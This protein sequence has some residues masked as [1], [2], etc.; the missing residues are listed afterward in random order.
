MDPVQLLKL[1]AKSAALGPPIATDE[2]LTL[3][4]PVTFNDVTWGLLV[5][6]TF[7]GPNVRLR[8]VKLT[9]VT[10]GIPTPS[11]GDA[12]RTSAGGVY[13]LDRGGSRSGRGGLK[14]DLNTATVSGRDGGAGGLPVIEKSPGL[15]EAGSMA[16][17]LKLTVAVPALKTDTQLTVPTPTLRGENTRAVGLKVNV[18]VAACPI[19]LKRYGLRTTRRVVGE[20]RATRCAGRW[21]TG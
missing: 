4:D 20:K 8:L 2:T 5:V 17:E 18:C 16:T 9:A 6:P 12:L 7:C 1:I 19:P 15:A 3:V 21:T 10:R 13:E 11:H 14:V